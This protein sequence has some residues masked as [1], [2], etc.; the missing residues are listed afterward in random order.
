MVESEVSAEG[1]AAVVAVEAVAV[2]AE[3][4][5]AAEEDSFLEVESFSLK[6]YEEDFYGSVCAGDDNPGRCTGYI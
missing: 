3:A 6:R 2:A 5:A 1:S 4:V